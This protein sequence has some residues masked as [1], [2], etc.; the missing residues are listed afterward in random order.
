ME[1]MERLERLYQKLNTAFELWEASEEKLTP[2]QIMSANVK[3]IYGWIA[4]GLRG[5]KPT[6]PQPET[7]HLTLEPIELILLIQGILS[8]RCEEKAK[9]YV[10]SS[11]NKDISYGKRWANVAEIMLLKEPGEKLRRRG[12]NNLE[13]HEYLLYISLGNTANQAAQNV[14]EKFHFPSQGACNEWIRDEIKRF[15]K[16]KFTLFGD[17]PKPDKSV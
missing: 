9:A 11:L 4:Q 16:E 6:I 1:D 17:L 8:R 15:K 3:R 12:H 2:E 14:C 5:E 10:K 13:M 7:I